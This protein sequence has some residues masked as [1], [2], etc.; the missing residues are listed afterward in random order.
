MYK[1]VRR[2]RER[3]HKRETVNSPHIRLDVMQMW[4]QVT[5]A[6]MRIGLFRILGIEL[7]LGCNGGSCGGII[8]NICKW[9]DC[10]AW[11]SIAS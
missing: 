3:K 8:K 4:A 6:Q 1:F 10:P 11:A 9:K 7:E 2:K 5:L